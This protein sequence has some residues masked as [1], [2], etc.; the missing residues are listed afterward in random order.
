MWVCLFGNPFMLF[1]YNVLAISDTNNCNK[2]IWI[3]LR[4]VLRFSRVYWCFLLALEFFFF[5][6]Y[7]DTGSPKVI[8]TRGQGI[9]RCVYKG[10]LFANFKAH[11]YYSY[12]NVSSFSTEYYLNITS[13]GS[14][15]AEDRIECGFAC[16]EIPLTT[17]GSS[18]HQ[19]KKKKAFWTASI[20]QVQQHGQVHCKLGVSSLQYSG[21]WKLDF[22]WRS[23]CNKWSTSDWTKIS[24]STAIY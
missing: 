22:H 4:N 21:R 24:E 9:S 7:I 17:S 6:I 8:D 11:K 12:L 23:N 19:K 1:F 13:I 18:W 14:D 10:A 3:F 5:F 15:L 2:C 20:W 16:L